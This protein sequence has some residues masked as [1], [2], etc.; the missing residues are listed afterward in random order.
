[1]TGR[2]SC[3]RAGAAPHEPGLNGVCSSP[4]PGLL[5]ASSLLRTP[6]LPIEPPLPSRG[7]VRPVVAGTHASRR[8]RRNVIARSIQLRIEP[9]PSCLTSTAR[10][11]LDRGPPGVTLPRR[12][13]GSQEERR[14]PGGPYRREIAACSARAVHLLGPLSKILAAV[15]T[16]ASRA[17]QPRSTCSAD[18]VVRSP[19]ATRS[20]HGRNPLDRSS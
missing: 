12:C 6:D 17:V 1:M 19:T 11:D 13:A 10:R 3:E 9:L 18:L 15:E 16:G 5:V 14:A 4:S 20:R 2:R 8:I 7:T